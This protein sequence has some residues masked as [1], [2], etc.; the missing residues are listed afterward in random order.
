MLTMTSEQ[1][2]AMEVAKIHMYEIL[3]TLSG[4]D[5]AVFWLLG[6]LCAGG[7]GKGVLLLWIGSEGKTRGG[8]LE[9]SEEASI[10]HVC[11]L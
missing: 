6:G 11:E 1:A 9:D 8:R 4:V 7:L 2:A 10:G 5:V 3:D